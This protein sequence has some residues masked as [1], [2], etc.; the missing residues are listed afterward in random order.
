MRLVR[1]VQVGRPLRTEAAASAYNKIGYAWRINADGID[2]IA[3][4]LP[5]AMGQI[6]LRD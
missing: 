5:T 6:S 3:M 4:Q 2:E 1:I